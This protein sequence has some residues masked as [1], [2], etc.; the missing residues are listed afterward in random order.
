MWNIV[1]GRVCAFVTIVVRRRRLFLAKDQ[2][3]CHGIVVLF[4]CGAQET[5]RNTTRR[6]YEKHFLR[7]QCF[8]YG[9]KGPIRGT[10]IAAANPGENCVSKMD[11]TS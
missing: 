6:G 7:S 2:S 5:T 11:A 10:E 1:F 4:G 8:R 3:V 9:V